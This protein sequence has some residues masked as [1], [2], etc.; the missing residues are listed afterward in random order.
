VA[1]ALAAKLRM[2]AAA[3]GCA[4]RKE[5]CARFRV[6]NPATQCDIDRL[7]KWV[8]GRSQP[9]SSSVYADLAGVIGTTRP[10]RWIAECDIEEFAAELSART[11][12]DAAALASSDGLTPRGT[13]RSPGLFGGVRTLTGA[14]AAY[15]PCW[16]PHFRGQLLRGSMRLAPG[17]GGGLIATYAES[18]IGRDVRL[19]GPVQ[20]GGGS[21]HAVVREP[22]GD[23]PLFISVTVP[24]PPASVMCGVMSGVA[25]LAHG[26]LPSAC[27]IVFVRVPDS[28]RLDATNRYFAPDQGAVANDVAEL[29][30]TVPEAARFDEFT[31]A[32]LGVTPNQ[33]NGDDQA[34]FAS[35]LDIQHLR[36][37]G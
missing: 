25:F 12:A 15:S 28:P 30:L 36:T 33:V 10:G 20:L 11:G 31:R 3:L 18:L 17:P 27:R 4:S 23:I 22:D 24:G 9:R 37:G 32:F 35:M 19:T 1:V 5:F 34:N 21:M 14:F 13:P 26:S 6:V 7:N 16:S 2:A 8:Q 29:G